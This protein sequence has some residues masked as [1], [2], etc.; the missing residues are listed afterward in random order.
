VER[1]EDEIISGDSLQWSSVALVLAG[2]IS[3][4]HMHWHSAI[5]IWC[6]SQHTRFFSIISSFRVAQRLIA[7][8]YPLSSSYSVRILPSDSSLNQT[9][10]KMCT[11]HYWT[12]MIP[13]IHLCWFCSVHHV[14]AA[15][16]VL[17]MRR[18]FRTETNCQF[19]LYAN[20]QS[21]L[22]IVVLTEIHVQ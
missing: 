1:D 9:N 19:K 15:L 4:A 21:S 12:I 3:Q 13:V 18:E 11:L 7:L 20:C 2:Q 10:S 17:I 8:L 16:S 14:I 22:T 6:L 5:V